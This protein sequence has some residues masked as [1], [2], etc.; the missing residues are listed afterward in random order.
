MLTVSVA[1]LSLN[2]AAAAAK[3]CWSVEQLK[4]D[5]DFYGH[6]V[7]QFDSYIVEDEEYDDADMPALDP[8]QVCI[9]ND[10]SG[11]AWQNCAFCKLPFCASHME[12]A[13]RDFMVCA[14]CTWRYIDSER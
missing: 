14:L 2:I 4:L 10:C 11:T 8:V 7:L 5:Q 13:D 9:V 12:Y 3:M 1:S 6:P